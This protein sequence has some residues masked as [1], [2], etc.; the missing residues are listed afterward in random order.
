VLDVAAVQVPVVQVPVAAPAALQLTVAAAAL[1]AA[2]AAEK[3]HKHMEAPSTTST[4]A[5]LATEIYIAEPA[6]A[7][8]IADTVVAEVVSSRL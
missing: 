5:A 3:S 1:L 7:T 2:V 8:A 6:A 4:P